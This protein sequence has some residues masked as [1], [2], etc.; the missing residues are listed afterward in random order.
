MSKTISKRDSRIRRHNRVRALIRGTAERPRL[1]VFR[2][3]KFISAQ[4]IDDKAGVTLAQAHGK[5]F[6]GSLMAQAEKVGTAVAER[7]KEKKIA[8]AVFDRGGF[9]YIGRVAKLADSARAAGL[10]I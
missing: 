4:L 8:T 7:G 1:A 5:E 6:G 9:N 10:K 3:N 2:S